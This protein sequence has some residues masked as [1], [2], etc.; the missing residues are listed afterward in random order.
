M[1]FSYEIQSC[2]LF[3]LFFLHFGYSSFNSI[4]FSKKEVKKYWGSNSEI[5]KKKINVSINNDILESTQY[6]VHS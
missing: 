6:K 4:F 1:N 5:R 2:H 3:P